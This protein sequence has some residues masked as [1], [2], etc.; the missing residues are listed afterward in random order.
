MDSAK[1]FW[2]INDSCLVIC[3]KE[4]LDTQKGAKTEGKQK[5]NK[6]PGVVFLEYP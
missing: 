5:P 6:L 1:L 3:N 2:G 4:E